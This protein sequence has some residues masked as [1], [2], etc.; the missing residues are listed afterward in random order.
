M[1]PRVCFDANGRVKLVLRS[2]A[3]LPLAVLGGFL[4]DQNSAICI[5]G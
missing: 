1:M 5:P 2:Q 4:I 3:V